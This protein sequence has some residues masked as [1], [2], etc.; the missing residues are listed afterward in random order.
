[1]AILACLSPVSGCSCAARAELSSCNRDGMACKARNIYRL[2]LSRR[3][4]LTP[5]LV[6]ILVTSCAVAM[7]AIQ[8][9]P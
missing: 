8:L 7:V 4:V 1:M 5:A 9:V 2:A 6:H 3:S